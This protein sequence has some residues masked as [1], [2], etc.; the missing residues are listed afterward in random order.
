MAS[1]PDQTP[2]I[3][4]FQQSD[5]ER[6]TSLVTEQFQIE[7]SLMEHGLP[8]YYLKYPQETKKPFLRL[9]KNLEP[10][11]LIAFL[12]RT[13]GRVVL[14]VVPKPVAK[15][16]NVLWNWALFFATI[17]TTLLTGYILSL[18]FVTR[19]LN[20]FIGAAA[21]TVAIMTILGSHEMGHKVTSNR[22]GIEATPPYFIPGPPPI[23]GI[24]GIGTF[25]AVIMQKSL[26][27]N[28]DVLFDVGSS[29][30]IV[31]FLLALVATVIGLRLSPIVPS[32]G[33]AGLP[34]PLVFELIGRFMITIPVN[35]D[36][37]LHPIAF[38][39]WVGMIVTMLNLLPAAML[40]GGHVARSALGDTTRTILM[41]LSLLMLLVAGF[42]P[43]AIL[44]LFMSTYRH[45]GP[46]DDVSPLSTKKKLY[47]VGL[48]IVFVLCSYFQY[49]IYFFMQLFG[50]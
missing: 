26:A 10:M 37:L 31:G 23:D 19:G 44:V 3:L 30:P 46:L 42:W 41:V 6:I 9:L 29:G 8:T 36:V 32:T 2:Q 47:A 21:F 24:L 18:D 25:G 5:F 49:F 27:P 14:K 33:Q 45:P 20:P 13:D 48:I 7:E 28:K 40:D 22:N 17:G 35:H 12:R 38:A 15:K 11:K 4:L 43:M 50:L 16:N 1:P 34:L 39:G